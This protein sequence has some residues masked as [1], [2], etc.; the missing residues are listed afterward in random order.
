[1]RV[2]VNGEVNILFED[3]IVELQQAMDKV[4]QEPTIKVLIISGNERS[5]LFGGN[6]HHMVAVKR[7]FYQSIAA[8]PY[9]LIASMKGDAIGTGFLVGSL[10]DFMVC[11]LDSCY[12]YTLPTENLYPMSGDE[13]FFN[14]RFGICPR[15]GSPVLFCSW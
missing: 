3:L 10:C 1:M 8:F 4:R 15:H 11:G 14:E 9:P 2:S 13:T 7:R 6:H 12:G 5:F